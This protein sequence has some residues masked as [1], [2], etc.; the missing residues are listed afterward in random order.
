MINYLHK[1]QADN[2]SYTIGGLCYN[3]IKSFEMY[4]PLGESESKGVISSIGSATSGIVESV[5]TTV[6]KVTN[7]KVFKEN[8]GESNL[9][10]GKKVKT[11]E[12]EAREELVAKATQKLIGLKELS[13]SVPNCGEDNPCSTLITGAKSQL[14]ENAMKL[15]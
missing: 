13:S 8:S 15:K 4:P 12:M 10:S 3:L 11:P 7:G 14:D 6:S 5:K 2:P 1:W 9:N